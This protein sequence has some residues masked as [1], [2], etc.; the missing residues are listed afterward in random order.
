MS[1][2][3]LFPF[4]LDEFQLE[5]IEYINQNH[6][7]VVCAP[8]GSGKTVVAEY[9][10][11]QALANNL[12]CFY[13]TPLK[14]LSNQKF[15]DFKEKFGHNKVGLL[16]GDISIESNAPIL[17]MTTEVYRNMLYASLNEG[18]YGGLSSVNFVILD[19]CHYMNDAQRG[20]VWEEAIIYSPKSIKLIALS[21]TI[22]NA[23]DLANWITQVHGSTKLI[24]SNHRSVPLYYHYFWNKKIYPLIDPVGKINPNVK[25]YKVQKYNKVTGFDPYKVSP[26]DVVKTL[27]EQKMLPA[28]YF[29]FSRRGCEQLMYESSLLDLVSEAEKKV[30]IEETSLYFETNPSLAHHTH[31]PYLL[32]GMAVHHAGMSPQWKSLIEKLFQKGLIKVVFATETLA[33]GVNMPARAVVISGV[34]KITDGGRRNL[35]TSELVQMAGRAGRR[36]IDKTGHVI[37]IQNARISLTEIANIANA[38]VEPLKSKFTPSYS[39][40]LNLLAQYDINHAKELISK[41]FGQYVLNQDVMPLDLNINDLNTELSDLKKPLCPDEIGDLNIYRS[42]IHYQKTLKMQL[43][44]PPKNMSK[45]KINHDLN[46][47]TNLA[48]AM[49]CHNCNVQNKCGS[50]NIQINKTEKKIKNI[51]RSKNLES[52]RNLKTFDAIANILRLKGYITKDKPSSLGQMFLNLRGS[53]ELFLAEVVLSNLF[54][55]LSVDELAAIFT[56]LVTE[57]TRSKYNHK[58]VINPQIELILNKIDKLAR[59]VNKLQNQFGVDIAIDISPRFSSMAQSFAQG[60]SFANL[61]K[62]N[63]YEEG[64]I[65]RCFRRAVD[66]ARQY[67]K[68]EIL[69][70]DFRNKCRNVEYLLNREEVKEDYL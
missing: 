13:T 47:V 46:E 39:M 54:D 27:F 6:N 24:V 49:P 37:I 48:Q 63:V 69:S 51:E 20:T 38:D 43:K 2:T 61:T 1:L 7:V 16:T 65:I 64:D 55:D 31:L 66:L 50:N 42:K 36:G 53:N 3:E 57:E 56:A 67:S 60:D 62:I 23:S 17:V 8:T 44:N 15:S 4:P 14:A 18:A 19:E 58:I 32:N 22:A 26:K 12:R 34:S 68:I 21:A 45:D 9:A 10:I 28:I 52:N 59:S 40:V 41:S 5:A 70:E 11:E 29:V 35:K 30:L 33:L 25:N